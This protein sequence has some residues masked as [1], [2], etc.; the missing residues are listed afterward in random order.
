MI[1]S[2]DPMAM[3]QHQAAEVRLQALALADGLP[4]STRRQLCF[5]AL[6]DGDWRVRKKAVEL[7][8][9]NPVEK[10]I[11]GL[12]AALGADDNAGKRNSAQEALI[13]LGKTVLP[14]LYKELKN[15]DDDV[16]K[17][18]VDILTGI[19]SRDSVDHLIAMLNDANPNVQLAAVEALGLIGDR[20]AVDHFIKLLK[21]TRN[22]WLRFAIIEAIG[23]LKDNTIFDRLSE[24]LA[25]P[26]LIKSIMNLYAKLG[27][28]EHVE[29]VVTL[30]KSGKPRNIKSAIHALGSIRDRSRDAGD[31]PAF[32][33]RMK[34]FNGDLAGI[35]RDF[36]T[37]E[38]NLFDKRAAL[39]LLGDLATYDD[40][41]FVLLFITDLELIDTVIEVLAADIDL[42]KEADYL[43]LLAIDDYQVKRNIIEFASRFRD[44]G[45]VRERIFALLHHP[46]GYIRGTAVSVLRHLVTDTSSLMKIVPLLNDHYSDVQEFAIETMVHLA[47]QQPF[48]QQAYL[49]L[50]E[51][52]KSPERD[53]RK[54]VA[55]IYGQLPEKDHIASL[56]LMVKDAHIDVRREAVRSLLAIAG[57]HGHDF[58]RYFEMGITEEDR[59]TRIAAAQGLVYGQPEQSRR[60]LMS[61]LE[62]KDP[63]V[64]AQIFKSLFLLGNEQTYGMLKER[65]KK[66]NPFV[67]ITILE[68]ITQ[69]E[70]PLFAATVTELIDH[71]E[72]EVKK[73]AIA[74]F[75]KLRGEEALG[76]IKEHLARAAWDVKAAIVEILAEIGTL[77][78]LSILER[79]ALDIHEDVEIRRIA[80]H[81]IIESQQPDVIAMILPMLMDTTFYNDILTAL[82]D[83]KARDPQCL[84]AVMT[85]IDDPDINTTM[86]SL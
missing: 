9:R 11:R 73:A 70:A 19:Q 58:N 43:R 22:D 52:R 64:R 28:V 83:I 51:V 21:I 16:R 38:P 66:E 25:Y 26:I 81:Y 78:A 44:S 80:V 68:N 48:Q 75:Y 61:S 40:L 76:K 84:K 14:Y 77:E 74:A 31:L 35:L 54:N 18:I 53:F 69:N 33:T 45:Q 41:L 2:K 57:A 34:H 1:N 46:Y 79:M 13:C 71:Q 59:Q 55:K 50:K 65:L 60:I 47:K 24:F 62:E 56:Q 10:D 86:R 6:G 39:L 23:N 63:I 20:R 29:H 3:M 30:L 27:G 8:T 82:R 85:Q 37:R 5:T 17:F 15:P 49:L 42:L 7:L 72:H 4:E 32:V 67:I 36:I 12:I